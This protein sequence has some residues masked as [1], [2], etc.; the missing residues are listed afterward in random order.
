MLEA[1]LWSG[2]SLT[3]RLPG[4]QEAEEFKNRVSELAPVTSDGLF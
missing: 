3:R 1:F 2:T 4:S